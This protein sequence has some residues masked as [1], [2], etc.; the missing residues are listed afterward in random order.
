MASCDIKFDLKFPYTNREDILKNTLNKYKILDLLLN[1]HP[2]DKLI[3]CYNEWKFYAV[4]S[5][6]DVLYISW[7][8]GS[9][10]S[11]S[12]A[13]LLKLVLERNV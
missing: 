11:I 4:K 6:G 3:C 10:Q 5:V 8:A 2:I 7:G 12:K 9:F 13:A 1:N